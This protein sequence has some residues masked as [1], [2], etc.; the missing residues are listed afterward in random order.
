[1]QILF[2]Y[3]NNQ[4]NVVSQFI[5]EMLEDLIELGHSVSKINVDDVQVAKESLGR[6]PLNDLEKVIFR[7][8]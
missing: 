8:I 2:L 4:Y 6:L 5:T 3:G 1:M 7:F